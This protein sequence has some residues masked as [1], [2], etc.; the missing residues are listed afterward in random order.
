MRK[1]RIILSLILCIAIIFGIALGSNG[2]FRTTIRSIF[3]AKYPEQIKII[4]GS[5]VEFDLSKMSPSVLCIGIRYPVNFT[6]EEIDFRKIKKNLEINEYKY[7][8]LVK[9]TTTDT[10]ERTYVN[11][12]GTG[13]KV[14]AIH[15]FVW[16]PCL[17]LKTKGKV[18]INLQGMFKGLD[19]IMFDPGIDY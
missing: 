11:F 17:I 10:I 1:R 2:V 4:K 16:S 7:D 8:R 5:L 13:Y 12:D 15:T 3:G 6:P 14:A 18:S 9:D 19:I